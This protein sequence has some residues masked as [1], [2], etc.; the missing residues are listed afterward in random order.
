MLKNES[1]MVLNEPFILLNTML[2]VRHRQQCLIA[3]EYKQ[4]NFYIS[5]CDW[6]NETL[7]TMKITRFIL[8]K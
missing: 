1:N 4:E 6:S 3:Y 8:E 7:G 2:H 5:K